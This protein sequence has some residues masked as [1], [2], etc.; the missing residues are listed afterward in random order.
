MTITV[1]VDE[2]LPKSLVEALASAGYAARTVVQQGLQGSEDADLLARVVAA[3][4]M[5]ITADR[6][7][8]SAIDYPPGTHHGI[9]VLRPG[10]ESAAAYVNLLTEVVSHQR[11]EELVGSITVAS[12]GSLRIRRA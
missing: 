7:F 11:L 4:E 6:G 1:K 8:G 5:L 3:G 2:D 12:P 10:R 9:L